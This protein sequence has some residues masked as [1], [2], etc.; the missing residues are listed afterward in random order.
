MHQLLAG[1]LVLMTGVAFAGVKP[2]PKDAARLVKAVHAATTAHD[3]ATL[4][5]VMAPDFVSSFGGDGGPD[6]ALAL[7]R[8]D[9]QY[10]QRLAQAT[11]GPC[12][13]HS[14]SYLEC[15]RNAG[16]G[17]RAGFRPVGGKWLFASFVAGD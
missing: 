15:P 4:R 17:H 11:S 14:P 10:L 5:S 1:A 16:V 3:T 8:A 9:P 7:W 6:E 2:I 12:Q 13:Y